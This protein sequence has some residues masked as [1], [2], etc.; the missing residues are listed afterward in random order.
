LK[1]TVSSTEATRT[2]I[3]V[4]T[5]VTQPISYD[6]P[7]AQ[8]PQDGLPPANPAVILPIANDQLSDK[9]ITASAVTA[10]ASTLVTFPRLS[11]SGAPIPFIGWIIGTLILV[12]LLIVC[13]VVVLQRRK[14]HV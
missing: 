14:S 5:V 6:N 9:V 3:K 11:I 13:I 7:Y 2:I 8:S 1:L 4:I 12:T 10:T